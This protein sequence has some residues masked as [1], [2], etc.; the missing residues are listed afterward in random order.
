MFFFSTDAGI[1]IFRGMPRGNLPPNNGLII[2]DN[3]GGNEF[4]FR[5]FCRSDSMSGNVGQFIGLNGNALSSNSIFDIA[6][7]Q[8][9][10][11]TVENR[12][13]SQ[14]ALTVG[15]EGI[16]TCRIPLQNGETRDINVGVYS[17]GFNSKYHL[18]GILY[19]G[20]W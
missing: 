4:R 10:E 14:N 5:I 19:C 1:H 12:V 6:R 13:G 15:Q 20:V 17:S 11:M 18:T 9:G 8:P 2:S 16:Y 3:P 7:Q